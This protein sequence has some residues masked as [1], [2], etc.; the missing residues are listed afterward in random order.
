MEI[1]EVFS[2]EAKELFSKESLEKVSSPERLDTLLEVTTPIGWMALTAMCIMVFSILMWAV[3]GALVEK[4]EGVGILLDSSGIVKVSSVSNGRVESVRVRTGDRVKKGDVIA[5]LELPALEVD[6]KV[7]RS[8]INLSQNEREAMTTAAQYDA[9]RY[10]QEISEVIVSAYDGIVDEITVVPDNIVAAGSTICTIRRDEGRDEMTGVMYV[11]AVNGKKI[12]PGIT[13]QL[14]PNGSN[15][16]E[17]GSLLAVVRSVSRYPVSSGAITRR[18]GNPELAQWFI[19]KND[20]AAMEVTFELVKDTDSGTGYLW[21]SSVGTHKPVTSGSVCSG[22]VVVDRKP[23]I[24]KVF[25]KVSQ[26]LRSR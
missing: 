9:K 16:S 24:E 7:T 10:E 13:L 11:P 4:V 6:S 12:Q 23:P 2:R 1:R 22:F 8:N 17:E 14:N 18:V 3:F 25:Y 20:N 5:T 26:W 15:S 21:T 19:A